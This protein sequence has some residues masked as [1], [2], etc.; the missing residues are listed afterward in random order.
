[1]KRKG[2]RRVVFICAAV[3]VLWMASVEARPWEVCASSVF[4]S[5]NETD[6][7][8]CVVVNSLLPID[9][10]KVAREVVE[11]HLKI[12]GPREEARYELEV[13]RTYLHYRWHC[14]W[15]VIYCDP[16]GK[17]LPSPF[18]QGRGTCYNDS[19]ISDSEKGGFADGNHLSKT[20]SKGRPDLRDRS[21]Q[22]IYRGR[23]P[24]GPVLL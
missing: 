6:V 20:A 22:C 2:K 10:S 11:E 18:A 17:I 4:T 21:G 12:N 8:L 7:R 9:G 16:R 3:L 24:G 15:G 14:P 1:M 5:G 19:R 23:D 13:Y